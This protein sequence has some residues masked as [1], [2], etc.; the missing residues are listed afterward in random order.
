MNIITYYVLIL[1]IKLLNFREPYGTISTISSLKLLSSL[2]GRGN[3]KGSLNTNEDKIMKPP[4]PPDNIECIK[5]RRSTSLSP[6]LTRNKS[7]EIVNTFSLAQNMKERQVVFSDNVISHSPPL[8]PVSDDNAQMDDEC[9]FQEQED[10]QNLIRRKNLFREP[11]DSRNRETLPHNISTVS[12]ISSNGHRNKVSPSSDK[13]TG[14]SSSEKSNSPSLQYKNKEE[15][16]QTSKIFKSGSS[17]YSQNSQVDASSINTSSIRDDSRTSGY[18]N[19]VIKEQEDVIKSRIEQE[20]NERIRES[21][22]CIDV[23]RFT[24][25]FTTQKI[26]S[27]D[28]Q[29]DED[30]SDPYNFTLPHSKDRNAKTADINLASEGQGDVYEEDS[31]EC[32]ADDRVNSR[33]KN[34]V[35]PT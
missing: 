4:P 9:R 19:N 7:P 11:S 22:A 12:E 2:S 5:R 34:M 8:S 18:Q 26:S 16:V 21:R 27:P 14:K 13:R 15:S 29:S 1:L 6:S 24:Q 23:K 30:E 33:K 25:R 31:D 32:K 20:D 10:D 35:R 17:T 28:N 3:D